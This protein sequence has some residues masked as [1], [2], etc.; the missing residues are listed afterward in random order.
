MSAA[1][2]GV[3][4]S[5][6]RVTGK[7]SCKGPSSS[8][9]TR[10]VRCVTRPSPTASLLAMVSDREVSARLAAYAGGPFRTAC[11]ALIAA[12]AGFPLHVALMRTLPRIACADSGRSSPAGVPCLFGHSLCP[13]AL[14]DSLQGA[15]ADIRPETEMNVAPRERREMTYVGFQAVFAHQYDEY[16]ASFLRKAVYIK[17]IAHSVRY[18]KH[19]TR[20][21]FFEDAV[22]GAANLRAPT[23]WFQLL[24]RFRESPGRNR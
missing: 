4:R 5:T 17:G 24:D 13:H 20:V 22:D 1:V 14:Q 19:V 3:G 7:P 11:R 10:L 8:T 16:S 21:G 12:L 2:R 6:F 18:E 23:R 9:S 15:T